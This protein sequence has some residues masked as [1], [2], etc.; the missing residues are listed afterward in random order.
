ML[1][2]PAKELKKT[3]RDAISVTRELG[4]DYLWV[5]PLCIIQDSDQDREVESTLL[6]SVYSCST[7]NIAA[8]IARDGTEGLF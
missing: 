8:A 4:I 1:S 2:I 3:F 5:D 6:S 7:I